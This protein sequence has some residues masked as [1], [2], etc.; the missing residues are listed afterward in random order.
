M[1]RDGLVVDRRAGRNQ[2]YT[3]DSEDVKITKECLKSQGDK[4]EAFDHR[5]VVILDRIVSLTKSRVPPPM[6]VPSLLE[7][8]VPHGGGEG[9][10]EEGRT[11]RCLLDTVPTG[12]NDAADIFPRSNAVSLAQAFIGHSHTLVSAPLLSLITAHA[13]KADVTRSI[14]PEVIVGIK[15]TDLM[16]LSATRN[17]G[18]KEASM[19]AIARELEAVAKCCASTAWC[20]WN[21]LCVFHFICA[22]LGPAGIDTLKKIVANREWVSFPAGAGTSVRGRRAGDHVI[23]DGRASFASGARYGEWPRVFALESDDGQKT[24]KP[25]CY[26]GTDQRTGVSVD[27]TWFSM[28]L[29]AS[30]TDHVNYKSV[31]S[32]RFASPIPY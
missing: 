2:D 29:R 31:G 16:G 13:A 8:I 30:A 5:R 10:K 14:E 19:S 4:L 18:G 11:V 22:Q 6:R 3:T 15:Q 23:I 25:D 7:R 12:C 26:R 17:I 9:Q 28:S 1:F 24:G 27:A 32:S 21:H 20:L